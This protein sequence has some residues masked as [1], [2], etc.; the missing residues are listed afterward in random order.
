MNLDDGVI[1]SFVHVSLNELAKVFIPKK[2]KPFPIQLK[3]KTHPMAH[4]TNIKKLNLLNEPNIEHNNDDE[5]QE[6]SSKKDEMEVK[7][8]HEEEGMCKRA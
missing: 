3:S 8:E 6:Q 1:A 7:E 2:L 4:P 5:T